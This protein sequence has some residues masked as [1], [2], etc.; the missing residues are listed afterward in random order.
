T[1]L[2]DGSRASAGAGVLAGEMADSLGSA[3]FGAGAATC[4][5]MVAG[6][7]ADATA[8][9]K[10]RRLMGRMIDAL[11]ATKIG[12]VATNEASPGADGVASLCGFIPLRTRKG[13][14]S[15]VNGPLLFGG[16][17]FSSSKVPL[18]RGI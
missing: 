3:C 11:W 17:A 13:P 18:S 8:K 9:S 5:G 6:P 14:S 4:G 15:R 16:A 7:H 12:S 2:G 10:G 1:G